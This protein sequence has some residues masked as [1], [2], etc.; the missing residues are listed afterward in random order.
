MLIAGAL[1]FN[2]FR[3]IFEKQDILI[4]NGMFI[5]Q[6]Q[7]I[8]VPADEERLDA[9]GLWMVPALVDIHMHIESSMTVPAEFSRLALPAG[10]GTVVADPHEMANV[11]GIEGIRHFMKAKT[12]MDIFYGLPSSVPST[13]PSCETTGG[14]IGPEEIAA[15]AEDSRTLCL[16]EVMN[17]HGLGDGVTGKVIA[18]FKK[19]RP[20]SPIE[21]HCPRITGSALSA[22]IAAGVWADHTHQTPASML[23]KISKGM[24][25]EIQRKSL[26]AENVRAI[27]EN[28]LY[29]HIAL[30]TDDV[31]PDDLVKGHLNLLVQEAIRLG[32]R[33]E[34]AVYCATYTPSR[35]MMLH[36]RG[37]I[38]PG[39]I[40]DFILLKD[41][42]TFEIASVYKRGKRVEKEPFSENTGGFPPHFYTSVRRNP[43]AR[44]HFVPPLPSGFQGREIRCV[45][46]GI[47]FHSTFTRRGYRVCPVRDGTLRWHEAG[48]CLIAVIERYGHEAP[49]SFGFGEGM[50]EGMPKETGALAT[51]LAHDHHNLLVLGT[52]EADMVLAANTVIARQGGLAAVR[53]RALAAFVPL[54]VG[55]IVSEAPVEIT[56]ESLRVFREVMEGLGYR[57]QNG[58]M[59]LCTLS[60][61]VS[62]ELKI[63]DKGLFDVSSRCP[64]GLYET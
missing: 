42:A 47:D 9:R 32:M 36:D 45:T 59:S 1:V 40:A 61:L 54:P 17:V 23:E 58:I 16:G 50:F 8:S 53:D 49:V 43:L 30:V 29:E 41:L 52:S 48:I 51:S 21:G 39:R 19:A 11:F 7:G 56:A 60:L 31:M 4:R 62:P 35:R 34:D 27:V 38:A 57:H 22:F 12:D 33:P 63:S 26:T 44:E 25:I 46:M 15:L 20:G 18:A 10:T 5:D 55:G 28:A 37:A 6:G 24:F 2:V 3:K 64:V 13:D 14:V